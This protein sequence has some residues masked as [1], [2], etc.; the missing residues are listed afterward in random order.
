VFPSLKRLQKVCSNVLGLI[1]FLQRLQKNNRGCEI[2]SEAA[3]TP[4][5]LEFC[6]T[7]SGTVLEVLKRRFELEKATEDGSV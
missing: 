3:K 7:L 1:I 6:C 4:Q 5:S 2:V